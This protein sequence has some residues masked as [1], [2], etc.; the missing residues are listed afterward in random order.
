MAA[1]D[2]GE[3]TEQPTARRLQEARENGNVPRSQDLTAAAA[4]LGGVL[5]LKFLG[6]GMLDTMLRMLHGLTTP[7]ELDSAALF[8]AA[9]QAARTAMGMLLPFLLLLMIITAVVTGLQAATVLS[10][11]RLKPKLDKLNPVNGVKRLFS[12]DAVTRLGMGILKMIFVA[13]VAYVSLAADIGKVLTLGTLV[14]RRAFELS[15][16][17]MF[18]MALRMAVVLLILALL[19]YAYQR[20][21]WWRKLKMTKQEVRDEM[22]R[23]DGDPKI[24]QRRKQL[25]FQLALQRIKSSVPRADVVVTNPTEFAVAL[26]YDEATMS[27]PRVVAKGQDLLA[28]RI[29]QVAQEHR[30][31]IVQRPPLARALFAAVEVGQ[32]I[33]PTFYRA[34][35]EVLA[36]VYQISGR[37]RPAG[38]AS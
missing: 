22:K 34:V 31:P 3:R 35:A 30:I 10:P 28:L 32:F 16:A 12:L 4:L 8:N 25:Q 11:K 24:K 38:V 15:A 37:A 2:T 1:D 27:A 17:L 14:P 20:W 29:R 7:S 36:Y 18:S 33:P 6:M 21:N 23:M 26:Q 19:D 9:G 13:A 5:L